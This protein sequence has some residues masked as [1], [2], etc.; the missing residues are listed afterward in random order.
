MDQRVR[1]HGWSTV[2][3]FAYR[4]I[5][6]TSLWPDP[7]ARF[8]VMIGESIAVALPCWLTLTN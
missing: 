6:S 1:C 3:V 2:G 4:F 7:G 8:T 5:S